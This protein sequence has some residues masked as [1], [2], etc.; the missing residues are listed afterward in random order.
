MK[1]YKKPPETIENMPEKFI[2]TVF[3]DKELNKIISRTPYYVKIASIISYCSLDD[4]FIRLC[5]NQALKVSSQVILT[6]CTH[7][8]D[9]EPED[10]TTL[11]QLKKEY[12]TVDFVEFEWDST[13]N[14]R[15]WHN[16]G[17]IKGQEA[18]REELGWIHFLDSDEIIDTKL[19]EAFL[20]DPHT[21][22][23]GMYRFASYW[24]FREPTHR[25]LPTQHEGRGKLTYEQA[26]VLIRK[27]FSNLNV[28]LNAER[29]QLH[30]CTYCSKNLPHERDLFN[31]VWNGE[32]ML[33]HFSW[34]RTK[35]E[36]LRKVK[37]FGHYDGIVW[38]FA[39]GVGS[40]EKDFPSLIEE[41]FSRP[42]NGKDFIHGY[43]YETVEDIFGIGR[44]NE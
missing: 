16:L 10:T 25:A 44:V 31:T 38:S 40:S 15:Y 17:R 3:H 19:F 29:E 12:P 9:G 7:L 34:V 27:E 23:Y 37:L 39:G 36:M 22:N 33:H 4:R 26:S 32:P 43:D 6:H 41:E 14:P 11:K 13:H 2:W 42:F 21:Y 8:F 35:E 20:N 18:V 1:G 30:V 5:I 28:N 24:Y